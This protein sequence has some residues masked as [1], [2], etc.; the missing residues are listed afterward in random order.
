MAWPQ[1]RNESVTNFGL[2]PTTSSARRSHT[3]S[4]MD[5]V[6][7]VTMPRLQGAFATAVRQ[8]ERLARFVAAMGAISSASTQDE[9]LRWIVHSARSL[10]NAEAATLELLMPGP[11]GEIIGAGCVPRG[12]AVVLERELL[13]ADE[14]YGILRLSG[15]RRR[16]DVPAEALVDLLCRHAEIAIENVVLREREDLLD[17]V[18]ALLGETNG[19]RA[20]T[21]VV[22]NLGDLRLDLARHEVVVDS[23]PAHLMPSEFRLLELLTEE[24]GRTYSRSDIVERLW[25]A[26]YSVKSGVADAHVARL[27]RKIERDHRHPERVLHVRG[28]GYKFVPRSARAE[29]RRNGV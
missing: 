14:R 28:V 2:L 12:S 17:R 16:L 29:D 9:L 22:R 19:R 3:W 5:C 4:Q 7:G 15:S 20:N 10:G 8:P 1:F 13:V 6:V 18:R 24:P 23:A 25:G 11:A 26:G 21:S 27:R